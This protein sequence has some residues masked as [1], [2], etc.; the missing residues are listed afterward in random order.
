MSSRAASSR[1][2]EHPQRCG[3]EVEES[4]LPRCCPSSPGELSWLCRA[5][6]YTLTTCLLS[7]R[8][9]VQVAVVPE[10][11]VP[12]HSG[13]RARL[14]RAQLLACVCGVPLLIP[15]AWGPALPAALAVLAGTGCCWPWTLQRL[16]PSEPSQEL[17]LSEAG[18]F[19]LEFPAARPTD[20]W[21]GEAG[22]GSRTPTCRVE[23]VTIVQAKL[24]G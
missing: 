1:L 6:I 16:P 10:E 2:P 20:L 7:R 19:L 11:L 15:G 9:A 4:V 13:E 24:Q 21:V 8:L 3:T 18:S 23:S 12:G 22:A 14:S 5:W 17:P